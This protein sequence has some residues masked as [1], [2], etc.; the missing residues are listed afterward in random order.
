MIKSLTKY[1]VGELRGDQVAARECYIAML[2]MDD[3][4]QTIS[5][6]KH[7]T[8][9]KPVERLKEIP[10]DSSRLDRTIRTGTL[11]SPTV[12]QELVAFLKENQDLFARSH[13]D[14]PRI[15]LPVIVHRLNVSPSFS[16]IQQKNRAFAQE[17]DQAIAE[18]VG[19]LQEASFIKEVYYPDWLTGNGGC[20]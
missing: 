17:Q 20:A 6:E 3:H 5:I 15:D 11:T 1:G 10:L 19:K 8:G 7:R 18:E 2:E 13:E 12:R 9:A 14:M 4:L 16:P